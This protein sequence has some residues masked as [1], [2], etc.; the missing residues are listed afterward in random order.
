MIEWPLLVVA[1]MLGSA[2]CLGMCGPFALAIGS[3]APRWRANLQRQSCYSAG[4]IFTYAALGAVVAFAGARLAAA[5]PGWANVPAVLAITAGGLLV[6]QGL[7]AAGVLPAGAV[8]GAAACPGAAAFRSLLTGRNAI[9]VF[10]AGI[11]TGLL[12]CGLLY[13]MLALAASTHDVPRGLATMV[14]FGLGTVP[15]MVAAG[16]GGSL[17]G[18]AARRRLHSLAAWC[19]V[20]TGVISIA[21]GAGY[22]S[23]TSDPPAG[24]PFCAAM[25]DELPA[26]AGAGSP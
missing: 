6:V 9:D 7:L 22:L 16:L 23:V 5:L 11:F 15:A 18:L 14:A 10:V 13:G 8:R 26:A 12:P 2:H 17:L 25:E 1:G 3:A 19:L 21:R 4:R 24:C 20:V